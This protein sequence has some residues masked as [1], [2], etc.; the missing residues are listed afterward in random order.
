[1]GKCLQL[2][3]LSTKLTYN[4]QVPSTI[5]RCYA[6]AHPD[7]VNFGLN[8]V[9]SLVFPLQGFWNVIVYIVTSQTACKRLWSDIR[10]RK[11][12]PRH[13]NGVDS[14]GSSGKNDLKLD[15]IARRTS[16]RLDSDIDSV[17]SLRGH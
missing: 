15:R 9:S 5:N 17:T 11:A 8:Y 7:Q 16:Q 1:M 13:G 12:M 6:L 14:M 4:V 10:D 2:T 3:S